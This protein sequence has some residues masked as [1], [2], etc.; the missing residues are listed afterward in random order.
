MYKLTAG[1]QALTARSPRLVLL[2]AGGKEG[3]VNKCAATVSG[4]K[5]FSSLLPRDG[6]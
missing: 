5:E 1:L 4:L 3:F 6:Q 2:H